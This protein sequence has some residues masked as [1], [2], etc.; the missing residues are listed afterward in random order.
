MANTN[1]TRGETPRPK[2]KRRKRHAA[3]G[4]VLLTAGKVLGTLLLMGAVTGAILASF[5]AVYIRTSIIP[6]ANVDFGDF[7]LELST[8]LYYNDDSGARQ[9]LRTIYGG[10]N[11][12]WMEYGDIPQYLIDAT[13]CTEDKRFWTHKGVDWI[14]TGRSVMAM[15]TGGNI[16]GGSTI[17]Q[18]L[19]KNLTSDNEVTVQRKIMEI[20]RALEFEKKYKKE[21][22]LEWYLNY[23]Y[24]GAHSDGVYT[25]AYTYF[26]K[27]VS[28][29]SLA[30]CASLISIT[31]N[32]SIY[33]PYVTGRDA[34]GNLDPAWGRNNN[35]KR[36]ETVI[37]WNMLDQG[38]ITQEEYDGAVA[39]LKAGLNFVRSVG[40]S[41]EESTYTWYEDQ[42]INDVI[43]D[44]MATKGYSEKVALN[45]VYHGGLQIETCLDPDVQ[46]VVDSVY[47][48]MENLP[49]VS[50]SG[51]QLQSGIVVLDAES[52]V[53]AISGGMGEKEGSRVFSRATTRRAPGSSF[54]PLSVYAPAIDAGLVTPGTVLDDTPYQVDS[55]GKAYP[56]NSYGYYKGRMT[57]REG[58]YIS[59]NPLAIKTLAQLTPQA[60]FDFLTT[61]LGFHLVEARE[62][63][64]EIKTDIALAPLSM[65]GLTDGVSTLEM[66]GAYA[67]FPRGGTY[68]KPRTYTRVYDAD[69]NIVLDNTTTRAPEQVFKSTTA[70]YMNSVLK[71]VVNP[72]ISG[73]TGYDAY[74]SGMT[75]A[76][77]TGSTDSNKDRWFVGYTPYYTAAVWTGYD[78]PE[79]IKATGNPAA[80]LWEKVMSQV[81]AGLEN[82]DFAKPDGAGE[83]VTVSIC[84]DSGMRATDACAL[85]PRGSRVRKESYFP[86]DAPSQYCTIHGEAV[87]MC[88]E[89]PL[90]DAN[91]APIPGLYHLARD[92]CPEDTRISVSLIDVERD[93]AVG[94]F[95]RDNVYTKAYMDSL[96]EDAYCT[97]HVET[98]GPAPYDASRFNIMDPATWPTQEQ[99]PGFDPLKPD[100]WPNNATIPPEG[101]PTDP[102]EPGGEPTEPP[103]TTPSSPPTGGPDENGPAIPA[104]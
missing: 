42:V 1:E 26:G 67:A 27:D 77:K 104:A 102:T 25:A 39:E 32:P 48:N 103:G 101:I 86:G 83:M 88:T 21:T 23:I 92:F 90:L 80:Q 19:I 65:G 45:M 96:G 22:I 10:A 7:S 56:S 79:R 75:I 20:F 53:V 100:T 58:I 61:K 62:V 59:S 70:W 4:D 68:L 89:S 11:R 54:K 91:G 14:R 30:E 6:K 84:A 50:G 36:A 24:L 34:D 44:L 40:E 17:T 72:N 87:D 98:P 5:A 55:N 52:N 97:V 60:S 71:D 51:Q 73:A 15:F 94:A 81:H 64:G 2:K 31:N 57:V 18:Q 16:Q 69:W 63:Q 28:Q 66:A 43:A 99:W 37:L 46:A 47:G 85:D 29:L 82:K 9:E 13:I 12:V 76:G 74:F 8:K 95:A 33:G 93:P 38:K 78:Q 41:H 3:A 49:Y 35:A